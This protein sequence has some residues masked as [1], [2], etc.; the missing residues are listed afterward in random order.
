MVF[1][2][3]ANVPGQSWLV[4]D[5]SGMLEISAAGDDQGELF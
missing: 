1:L 5:C 2:P 4:D 3:S